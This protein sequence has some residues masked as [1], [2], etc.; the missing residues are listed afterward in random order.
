MNRLT[1]NELKLILEA[2]SAKYGMGYSSEPAVG[3]LQAK[4]SIMLQVAAMTEGK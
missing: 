4:L 2:L 3:Q 1:Y